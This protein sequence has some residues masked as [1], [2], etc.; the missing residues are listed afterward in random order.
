MAWEKGKS[1]NPRGRPKGAKAAL[2]SNKAIKD[3]FK[4]NSNEAL[5]KLLSILRNSE[6]E[7]NQLKAAVKILD[8]TYNIVVVEEREAALKR[9]E[10]PE[11]PKDK[12]PTPAPLI[13]L[14]AVK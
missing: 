14:S 8:V 6:D 2:P 11:E 13:S 12:T 1:G 5:V 3:A 10:P 4:K 9:G 7:G